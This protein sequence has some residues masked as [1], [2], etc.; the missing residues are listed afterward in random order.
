MFFFYI[1]QFETE[2][3]F[4]NGIFCLFKELIP[5]F[6][7]RHNIGQLNSAAFQESLVE[8]NNLLQSV[9]LGL[10]WMNKCCVSGGLYDSERM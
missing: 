8:N 2:K 5:I 9:V 6:N 4:E 3:S 10:Y 1:N 7:D